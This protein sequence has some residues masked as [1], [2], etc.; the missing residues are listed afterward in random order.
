MRQQTLLLNPAGLLNECLREP[1]AGWCGHAAV[2]VVEDDRNAVGPEQ[3]PCVVAQVLGDVVDIETRCEIRGDVAQRLG[4]PQP[5]GCLF[6]RPRAVDQGGQ[7]ARNRCDEALAVIGPQL[8][9]TRQHEDA[10]RR[11]TAAD[12]NR[13]LVGAEAKHRRRARH[14]RTCVD[15]LAR[16][17]R[18]RQRVTVGMHAADH[19][20]HVAL[21]RR[22]PGNQTAGALLPDADKCGA[23]DGAD[24]SAGFVQRRVHAAGKRGDLGKVCQQVKTCGRVGQGCRGRLP[25]LRAE[26][27]LVGPGNRLRLGRREEPLKVSNPVAAVAPLVDAQ[28]SDPAGVAPCAHGVGVDAQ[29]GGGSGDRQGCVAGFGGPAGGSGSGVG[30]GRHCSHMTVSYLTVL[31]NRPIAA[32][33]TVPAAWRPP[34][35]SGAGG[36]T[37]RCEAQVGNGDQDACGRDTKDKQDRH[38][39]IAHQTW[40]LPGTPRIADGGTGG[41]GRCGG[42]ERRTG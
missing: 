23:G 31:A 39:G 4:A 36:T 41:I 9:G 11:L 32:F 5:S 6:S 28:I 34:R 14:T 18:K 19:G 12:G 1:V 40:P 16:S 42:G 35:A 25:A 24:A 27:P 7:R 33:R 38:P 8:H 29:H 2:P 3:D 21:C 10:P 22:R 13:Q 17:H 20:L 37:R 15:G 26:L 30:I